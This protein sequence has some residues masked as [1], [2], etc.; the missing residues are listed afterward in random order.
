MQYVGQRG[1]G[2]DARCP[3]AQDE[4][5]EMVACTGVFSACHVV[6]AHSCRSHPMSVCRSSLACQRLGCSLLDV[7]CRAR[8]TQG[9]LFCMLAIHL[10]SL[11]A[12]QNA[13]PFSAASGQL[14]PHA[15]SL[16]V[17]QSG[18]TQEPYCGWW[19]VVC[20]A[21]KYPS[22]TKAPKD[23]NKLEAEVKVGQ[24]LCQCSFR[25]I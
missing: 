24:C 22:S 7:L 10:V 19:Y 12:I 15:G 23:W 14:L 8:C 2:R 17:W 16:P 13:Q 3:D 11:C 21:G 6:A 25:F 1:W 18:I 4:T 9:L 20:A 5:A